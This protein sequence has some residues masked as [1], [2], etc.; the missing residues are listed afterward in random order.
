[1]EFTIN[2]SKKQEIIDITSKIKEILKESKVKNGTLNVYTIHTTS[3][4][5]INENY[6]PNIGL[7]L[8][9]LLNKIVPDGRW[10]HDK[11][12]NN[13]SAHL[14]SLIL[15]C[16]KTIPVKNNELQLGTWQNIMFIEFDG[17]RKRKIIVSIIP[18]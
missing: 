17:P 14:K 11:I 4:I 16:S 5:I 13:A 8:L 9:D 18:N 7:D 15:D 2:T 10:K 12:D 1:M 3:S 6:D